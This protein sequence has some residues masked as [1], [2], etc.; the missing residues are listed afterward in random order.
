MSGTAKS[1]GPVVVR[2]ESD[3]VSTNAEATTAKGRPRLE[4]AMILS[5]R[6]FLTTGGAALAALA[7]PTAA[8]ATIR[9]IAGAAPLVA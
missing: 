8:H 2:A 9:S 7:G 5:R 1:R 4:A 6:A 3:T